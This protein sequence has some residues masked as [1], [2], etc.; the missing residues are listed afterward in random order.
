[1]RKRGRPATHLGARRGLLV[2]LGAATLAILGVLLLAASYGK[3]PAEAAQNDSSTVSVEENP[4]SPSTE[5]APTPAPPAL[6]PDRQEKVDLL[7]YGTTTAGLGVLRGLKLAGERFPQDLT[8]ALV[9]L[10]PDLESPLVQGLSVEDTYR[11]GQAGGFWEDFRREVIRTYEQQGVWPLQRN[12]RLIHEPAVAEEVLNYLVFSDESLPQAARGRVRLLCVSGLPRAASDREGERYLM[13]EEDDGTLV[14]LN[15]RLFVDASVEADLARLLGASYKLGESPIAYCDSTGPRPEAPCRRNF[16][17][18]AP[19]SLT[20]LLTLSV[21]KGEATPVETLPCFDSEAIPEAVPEAFSEATVK[22]FPS[23]WSMTHAL[24]GNTRELNERWSDWADPDV[25]FT[26]Y[27]EPEKRSEIVLRLQARALHLL[28]LIQKDYP[29]VGLSSLPTWPYVRGE[30][31]VQ[32]AHVFSMAEIEGEVPEPIASGTYAA[33]DRHDPVRGTL[34]PERGAYVEVPLAATRPDRHPA[35]LVATAL[36]LTSS[37]YSSACRMEPV[38]ANVGAACGVQAA[39]ALSRDVS[40]TE[41]SYADVRAELVEQGHV[42][43]R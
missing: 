25:S 11:P 32:G 40:F 12:G 7:I 5:T 42:L 10:A 20:M 43:K 31:M 35:L 34:Q 28:A 18:T 23:S 13:V 4:A 38:R 17:S 37:A 22:S 2:T 41:V 27:M 3:V 16:F 1:L 14:R 8:V 21:G 15:T 33:F 39:L 30:V 19:Q 29:K 36:S 26:W 24:P 9:S 6:L